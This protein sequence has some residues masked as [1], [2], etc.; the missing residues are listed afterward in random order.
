MTRRTPEHRVDANQG[1]IVAALR[2]VGCEVQSLAA[3]GAG[4]PDLLV[5][6]AGKT[7]LIE[8]KDGS[9]P[10]SRRRLNADQVAWHRRW[11]APVHTV[12]DVDEALAAVGAKHAHQGGEVKE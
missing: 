10:P 4:C 11:R 6:R 2:A 8:V 12:N 5:S 7:Y 9:K 3:V 1:E